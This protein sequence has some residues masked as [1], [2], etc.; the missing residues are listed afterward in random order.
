MY[1]AIILAGGENSKEMCRHTPQSY[2]ALIDIAGKPMVTFVAEALAMSCQVDRIFVLGPA[3]E[4]AS[5]EFPPGTIICESGPTII[6][7]IRLGM[8]NLG[9]NRPVLVATADIPLLTA[10]AVTDFLAQCGRVEA[11]LYY[12][13]VPKEVNER[14]FPGN[15][16][17]YVRLREGVF[18]GGN[19][20]LVKPGIVEQ[21]ALVAEKF[22]AER[23]HPF[24]LCRILGWSFVIRFLLG[25]LCL[26]DVQQR[27][28]EL[29]GVRGAVVKSPYPEL[30]IDVDKPS[31]LELVR[32]TF[33]LRG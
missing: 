21:C 1:D 26:E 18:T 10:E 7:T 27:V 28:S 22:I 19:L 32:A 3:A 13:I 12:P 20:F 2:E 15:K 11:D 33:S 29:L 24:V 30:G 6:E 5:C 25:V 8:R 31:D 4:L 23:K 9:H 16:R 14:S 17:T